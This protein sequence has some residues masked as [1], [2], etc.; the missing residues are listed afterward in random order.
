MVT[1]MKMIRTFCAWIAPGVAALLM[2]AC[3]GFDNDIPESYTANL[4]GAQQVPAVASTASGTGLVTVDVDRSSM[5]ASVVLSGATA[6]EV[7]IHQGAVGASGPVTF[8]L[9]LDPSGV[10]VARIALTGAQYE[11]L[12]AGNFYLDAHTAANPAG[13]LRGQLLFQLPNSQQAQ[14]IFPFRNRVPLIEQQ[15]QLI[16]EIYYS[17]DRPSSGVGIGIGLGF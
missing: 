12:R 10:W 13:E 9:S 4:T 2:T 1:A 3:G 14:A 15:R 7:H 6:T 5:L 8:P 16:D 11:A 17:N